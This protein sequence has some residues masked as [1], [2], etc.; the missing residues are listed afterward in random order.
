[1]SRCVRLAIYFAALAWTATAS[2]QQV[3][4]RMWMHEH[5]P[6]VSIDKE[7]IAEFEKANPDIKVDHEIIPV[8]EYPTKLLTA[9]AAGSGP[10]IFNAISV[11][12]AQYYNARILAPV[13]YAA[14]GFADEAALTSQFTSGFDGIRFQ[15]KLYGIPTEVS[16]WA[17]FTNDRIWHEAG[18]DPDKD[19]P[20]TWETFPAIAEKLTQRDPNGVPRRR[21]FDFNWP[22]RGNIWFTPNSMLHQLGSAMIDEDKYQATIDTP[23]AR[24][25][26]HYFQD[27]VKKYH[28]GGPQYT[29]TRT[30]F[31][32]GQLATDCS[33]GIWGIPQMAAA[34]I[35]WSVHA[36][37]RW[38]HAVS[39]N[40]ADAYAYYMMV[41]ARSSPA[42]QKAAW[43]L[44]RFYTDHAEELFAGAGLFV[45]RKE[46]T[47]SAAY[48]TNP[49][50]P[51]FLGELN[52]AKFSPRIVGYD[53]VVDALLRGRD[54]ILQ[55]DSVEAVLPDMEGEVNTILNRERARA[56]AMAK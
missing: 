6:R 55:G 25:V 29:D 4:L 50:A 22:I 12:V 43:K 49:A 38:E 40:G 30:D 18:L 27:W 5:P 26:F 24:Q 36:L 45:P 54:R 17:C 33:F 2:A 28:L 51:F 53:Q 47:D 21:G 13:D 16:N 15:G 31:L 46:V 44:V 11:L 39:D 37:P 35:D 7:I 9:F 3:T 52:K 23:Q 34:K 1:M 19:F 42:A 14:A 56:A 20:K 8:A 32:G 48:K 41:N 10:D